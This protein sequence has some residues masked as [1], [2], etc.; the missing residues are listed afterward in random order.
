MQIEYTGRQVTVTPAL[1]KLAEE[2]L[3]RIS[4]ILP[5]ITSVHLVLS[6]EKYRH[7]AELTIKTR[8]QNIVGIAEST[9]MDTA[10][11]EAL[12]KA[13]AQAIRYKKRLQSVK[14]QP[15]AEKLPAEPQLARRAAARTA[16]E[17]VE[18]AAPSNGHSAAASSRARANGK[19]PL[20]AGRQPVLPVTVHTFPAKA[21][22]HEP[23]IVRSVDSVALRPMTLEEAVKEAEFRDR[24][25]FVFRN[26]E[27]NVC[28]LHRKRDGRMELI[29]AP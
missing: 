21:P 13:E 8:Q 9:S 25:V 15:R 26:N 3:A 1:R 23:H 12:D 11:R 17:P 14:R 2:G 29:E 16:P 5:R 18:P 10:L 22:I 28:V 19:K 7:C 6:S 20:P 27:G 4:K 24:E